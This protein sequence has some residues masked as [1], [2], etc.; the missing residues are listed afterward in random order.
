MTI[1]FKRVDRENADAVR[2]MYE[3]SFPVEERVPYE[4]LIEISNDTD[5]LFDAVYDNAALIG[6]NVLIVKGDMLYVM[7]LAIDRE[8][9]SK[10][11]GKAIVKRLLN[12]YSEYRIALNIEEVAPAYSNYDQRIK[13]KAF[14]QSLGFEAQPYLITNHEGIVFETMAVHGTVAQSEI[15][16]WFDYFE[17]LG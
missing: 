7:Y 6:M 1:E 5:H 12:V 3:E 2:D 15:A 8:Y 4:K 9:R 14:Y 17:T 10:G 16:E 11:Y 13:R